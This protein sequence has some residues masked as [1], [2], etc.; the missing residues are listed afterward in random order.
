MLKRGQARKG[1]LKSGLKKNLQGGWNSDLKRNLNLKY[2]ILSQKK[3]KCTYGEFGD[4]QMEASISRGMRTS[5]WSSDLHSFV[6]AGCTLP[7][8]S[9]LPRGSV[10]SSVKWNRHAPAPGCCQGPLLI[11]V[12]LLRTLSLLAT[13]FTCII[14]IND[15][16][17]NVKGVWVLWILIFTSPWW[18]G[19]R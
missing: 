10:F 7:V 17:T 12:N 3:S 4:R 11:T 19:L 1:D 16:T 18:T 13:G 14:L 8:T 2:T 15:K 6:L 5:F 9:S